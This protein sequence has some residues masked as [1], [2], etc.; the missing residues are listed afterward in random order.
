MRSFV[1]FRSVGIS[2]S[3]VLLTLLIFNLYNGKSLVHSANT[4]VTEENYESLELFKSTIK[5]SQQIANELDF[6]I[7]EYEK[8]DELEGALDAMGIA[9]EESDLLLSEFRQHLI[10]PD[11]DL[12]SLKWK[13]EN[14]LVD[15]IAGLEM[16]LNGYENG[17]GQLANEGYLL[18]S[19]SREEL[20]DLLR[21]FKLD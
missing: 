13:F 11:H 16:Q 19:T 20:N 1:I 3:L 14:L 2:F 6:L 8:T 12:F 18:V 17:N 21:E 7:K 10:D 4:Q 5:K 15:F 9:I